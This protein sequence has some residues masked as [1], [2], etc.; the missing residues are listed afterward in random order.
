MRAALQGAINNARVKLV[1][2]CCYKGNQ[3]DSYLLLDVHSVPT[4]RRTSCGGGALSWHQFVFGNTCFAQRWEETGEGRDGAGCLYLQTC[5]HGSLGLLF[6]FFLLSLCWHGGSGTRK[7]ESFISMFEW[8]SLTMQAHFQIPIPTSHIFIK[9]QGQL[10]IHER[11]WQL[12]VANLLSVDPC[13]YGS[14]SNKQL[15]AH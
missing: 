5:R 15:E 1:P 10:F 8:G 7:V 3:R 6:F 12:C 2:N 11:V 13:H 4:G 14:L 9:A